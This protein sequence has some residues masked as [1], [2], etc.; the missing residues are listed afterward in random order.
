M[1]FRYQLLVLALLALVAFVVY[2]LNTVHSNNASQA[3]AAYLTLNNAPEHRVVY[4]DD[5]VITFESDRFSVLSRDQTTS[6]QYNRVTG[7]GGDYDN[8]P[9]VSFGRLGPY[10]PNQKL[11]TLIL[12]M[13]KFESQARDPNSQF[14]SVLRL[15]NGDSAFAEFEQGIRLLGGGNIPGP[16][17][18][19]I[20]AMDIYSYATTESTSPGSG[21]LVTQGGLGVVK[22]ANIGGSLTVG[23][24]IT[25]SQL[26]LRN[27]CLNETQLKELLK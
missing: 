20:T 11:G 12:G 8:N 15:Y 14:P 9:I 26:C 1:S 18:G 10:S 5:P 16:G 21:A 24:T 19:G 25:V 3:A 17:P 13:F 22:S 6:S 7:M 27:V 4:T 2:G 23:G